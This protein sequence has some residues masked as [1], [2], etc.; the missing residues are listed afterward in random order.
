MDFRTGSGG[1]YTRS[2]LAF[3]WMDAP[4]TVNVAV[5]E[6]W[7]GSHAWTEVADLNTARRSL[8]AG[9]WNRQ[10]SSFS[11][12]WTQVAPSRVQM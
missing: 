6:S 9:F 7:N 5:C 12:W 8:T 2:A 11:I 1:I 4:G 3:W 10:Y